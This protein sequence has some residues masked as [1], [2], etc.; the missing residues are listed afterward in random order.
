LFITDVTLFRASGTRGAG[1]QLTLTSSQTLAKSQTKLFLLES[2]ALLLAPKIFETF[3]PLCC[4]LRMSPLEF[5]R[6]D[7]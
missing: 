7:L 5:L 4:L 2:I 3:H 6:E 1:G